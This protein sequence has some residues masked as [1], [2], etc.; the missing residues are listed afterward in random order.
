MRRFVH[1]HLDRIPDETTLLNFRHFVERHG[2]GRVIFNTVAQHLDN[3]GLMLREGSIIDASLIAAP[4][5]TKNA[6]GEGE[7][8]GGQRSAE[9]GRTVQGQR[10]SEGGTPVP[11]DQAHLR[12]PQGALPWSG[13]K[14]QQFAGIGWSHESDAGTKIS[15]CVRI[16]APVICRN[17]CW[18][19]KL[20]VTGGTG[21]W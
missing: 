13:K 6:Q 9:A 4:P 1:L 16:I 7:A 18:Q 15:G 3:H 5:S 20:R 11:V 10:A 8:T 21:R 17:G 19:P 2:L 12:V 14:H